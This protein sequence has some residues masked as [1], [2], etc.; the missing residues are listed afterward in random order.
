MSDNLI[1]AL[2][3]HQWYTTVWGDGRGGYGWKCSCGVMDWGTGAENPERYERHP[4]R[5]AAAVAA[6][7]HVAEAIPEPHDSGSNDG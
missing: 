4:T 5:A 2:S 3:L 1:A 6:V 7:R